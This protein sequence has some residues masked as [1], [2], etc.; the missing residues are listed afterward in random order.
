MRF[1]EGFRWGTATSA[2]QVEGN[3]TASDWWLWEQQPGRIANG[4][5]SGLA[6]DWWRRAEYDFDLMAGL[7]HNAARISIEWARLE[8]REGR[9][10][11]AALARYLEMLRALRDR[12]M[13]PLVTLNHVTLPQWVAERGGWL[14]RGIA[15]AFGAYAGRFARAAAPLTDFWLTLNEPVG[16]LISAYLAG[17]FAPGYTSVT[18]L[19]RALV[20]S[21]RAHAA[22]Y[23]AVRNAHPSARVGV[24]AYLR[25]A[26]AVVPGSRPQR[27]LA[28]HLD[29]LVNWMYLDALVLGRLVGPLGIAVSV[30]E[31]AGTLDYIGVN[32]YTRS[33]VAFDLRRPRT[34]FIRDEPR[35]EAEVSDGG[36]GEIYPDGLLAVL[37]QARR[38]GL[39][40]YV[41]ENGV[42]DADDDIRPR[43]I[44]EHLRRVAQAIDEGV[45]VL[46]YYHWSIVD[47]FEWADGWT[48][49]FGLYHLDRATQVR[50]PRPSAALYG[51][52]CRRNALP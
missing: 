21:V 26:M 13:E 11:D 40:I 7:G 8:P 22:A 6:C 24:A 16:H 27:W 48:L 9:W 18:A 45:P 52:I 28:R 47:N 30:P 20:N 43:F 29:R 10:D 37:R 44:V 38:Y 25:P 17:R 32:Y 39:P 36:Y 2:Y 34:L 50:T 42:P 49:R 5:R 4:D 14:W 41:T 33:H 12:G 23:R 15:R 3:N 19:G 1:P 35:H 51:E 31:A 46:G